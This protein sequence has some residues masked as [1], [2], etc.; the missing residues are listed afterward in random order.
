MIKL[1]AFSILSFLFT[2]SISLAAP[3]TLQN[4]INGF[5]TVADKVI[6]PFIFF[7][8]FLM[9]VIGVFR[10]FILDSHTEEGRTAAKSLVIYAI[11]FF[12]FAIIFWGIINM[13][14]SSTGIQGKEQPVP[15]Y[16]CTKE[17]Y[18]SDPSVCP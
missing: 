10:F 13:F 11:A 18:K 3:A 6:V 9:F 7:I 12:V 16:L 14:T 1:L 8:A 5:I 2:P 15:D 4:F 17:P